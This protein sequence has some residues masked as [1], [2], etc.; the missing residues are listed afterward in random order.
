MLPQFFLATVATTRKQGRALKGET[1]METEAL[2]RHCVGAAAFLSATANPKRL[3]ILQLLNQREHSVGEL[4][5][6]VGLSQSALSQHL[7][8]LRRGRL[9]EMRRDA[10]TIYY[11]STS[12]AVAKLL[13]TLEA[14]FPAITSQKVRPDVGRA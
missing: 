9:F 13:S 10:Q 12:P 14:I 11:S 5:I 3:S 6:L 8:R 7:S 1:T 4:S 2:K